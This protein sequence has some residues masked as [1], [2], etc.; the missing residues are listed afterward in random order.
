MRWFFSPQDHSEYALLALVLVVPAMVLPTLIQSF[1]DGLPEIETC[2]R[3][4]ITNYWR[5]ILVPYLPYLLY[6]YGLWIGLVF[7]VLLVLTRWIRHDN[8]IGSQLIKQLH[9]TL[10]PDPPCE[11]DLTPEVF[12]RLLVAYQS[13]VVWLKEVA[14]RYLFIIVV[15]SLGLLY[16]QLTTSRFTATSAA[17]DIAKILLWLLLGPALISFVVLVALGYQRTSR[18][19]QHALGVLAA[20]LAGRKEPQGL[21]DRVVATRNSLIWE[22]GSTEFVVS[23]VKSAGVAMPLVIALSGYVIDALSRGKWL[24]IFLPDA[25]VKVIKSLYGG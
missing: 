8:L 6:I 13:Y 5:D 3:M 16:E 19:L 12:E 1:V 15:V 24:S 7:P 14:E 20:A 11:H 18:R 25:V 21:F 4:D 23:V 22:R 17:L 2:R 9:E 10:P